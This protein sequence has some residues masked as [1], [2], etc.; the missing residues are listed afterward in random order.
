MPTE[1]KTNENK[2][3]QIAILKRSWGAQVEFII[4]MDDL[5]TQGYE[6]KAVDEGK[7]A[8]AQGLTGGLSSYYYFQKLKR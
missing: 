7:S 8:D 6:L 3:D 4:A 2:N 5:T 1:S